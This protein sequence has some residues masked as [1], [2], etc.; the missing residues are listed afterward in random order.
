MSF[1]T[2]VRLVYM[3]ERCRKFLF[4]VMLLPL[5]AV[6]RIQR[7]QLGLLRFASL[8]GALPLNLVRLVRGI[9]RSLLVLSTFVLGGGGGSATIEQCMSICMGHSGGDRYSGV[10]VHSRWIAVA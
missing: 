4:Y 1:G 5:I 7:S 2:F 9:V 8:C 6:L 3:F 10:I